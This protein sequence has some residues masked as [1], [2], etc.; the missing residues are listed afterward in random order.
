M[1][2]D[3]PFVGIDSLETKKTVGPTRFFLLDP[4]ARLWSGREDLNLRPPAPK[5]GTLA[6][7]RHAPNIFYALIN[8]M[9][10]FFEPYF[11]ARRSKVSLKQF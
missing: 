1:D 9:R 5:A 10:A 8:E 11:F 4:T 2:T 7:L 6:R 3:G